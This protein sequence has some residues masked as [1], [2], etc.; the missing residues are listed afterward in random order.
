[1]P[2]KLESLLFSN[3]GITP[4]MFI[5]EIR[6][7]RSSLLKLVSFIKKKLFILLNFLMLNEERRSC[8]FS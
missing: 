1:M 8:T 4:K 2:L 7:F 3:M 5:L 6:N